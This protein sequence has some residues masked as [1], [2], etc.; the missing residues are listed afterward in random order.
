[1]DEK[2]SNG[3]QKMRKNQSGI[4][5]NKYCSHC[6]NFKQQFKKNLKMKISQEEIINQQSEITNLINEVAYLCPEKFNALFISDVKPSS[7]NS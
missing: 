2:K 6:N 7:S 1:M 5:K 3:K 4:C